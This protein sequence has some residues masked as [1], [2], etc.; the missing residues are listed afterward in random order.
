MKNMKQLLA[1][2]LVLLSAF[3]G[4]GLYARDKGDAADWKEGDIVFQ[5]S[6]SEQSPLIQYA[7]GSPWTHCGIV[8]T[9]AGLNQG[10]KIIEGLEKDHYGEAIFSE[11]ESRYQYPLAAALVC[12]IAELF[13]F[14][15]R[16]KKFNI[17]KLLKE[18]NTK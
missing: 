10:L 6:K 14:E 13:I 5:I 16:N 4:R 2:I 17:D 11:Y 1:S 3:A 8:R 18:K 9:V 12:L 7:T 15:R